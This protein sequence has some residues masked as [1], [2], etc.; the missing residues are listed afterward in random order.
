MESAEAT[1]KVKMG[2]CTGKDRQGNVIRLQR[3]RKNPQESKIL[4]S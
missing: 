3:E 2:K 4:V 1:W